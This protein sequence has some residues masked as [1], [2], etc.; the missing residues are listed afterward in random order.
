MSD[1]Q[2]H[3]AV[4]AN[5]QSMK[6]AMEKNKTAWLDL[7]D[8]AAVVR[9]PVGKSPLDPAGKGHQGKQN[10]EVFWDKVIAKG[11]VQLTALHRY[12]S[13][14][15]HCAVAIEGRNDMGGIKTVVEMLVVYEVNP[16]G[17]LLSLSAFW[18]FDDLML[19]IKNAM[20]Q[21]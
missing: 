15:Y 7:F 8:D 4:Q 10:I 13:G 21:K 17:K 9:D 6:F 12:T 19:Q 18:S 11:N 16:E 14:D 2:Q 3:L 1:P 20:T 5:I